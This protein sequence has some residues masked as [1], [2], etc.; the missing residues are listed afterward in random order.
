VYLLR[1]AW[2]YSR[3]I[4]LKERTDRLISSVP[5]V[6]DFA[7][8]LMDSVDLQDPKNTREANNSFFIE[9]IQG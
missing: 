4:L 9:N 1:E 2:L 3:H 5:A 6:A 8:R 7:N